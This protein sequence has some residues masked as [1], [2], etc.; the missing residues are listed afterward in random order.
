MIA[1]LSIGIVSSESNHRSH[2]HYVLEEMSWLAN[3]FAQV[4]F[5]DYLMLNL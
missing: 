2:W 1:E 5:V 4:Q 3:D